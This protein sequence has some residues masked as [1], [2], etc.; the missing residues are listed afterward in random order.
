MPL[1]KYFVT[2]GKHWDLT[3][4]DQNE[5]ALDAHY[6][7]TAFYDMM[8]ERYGWSGIDGLGGELVSRVHV[9]GKYYVNA[10]WDG[11]RANFGNGDCDRYAPLTTLAIVGHEF[12]HGVT[13]YTSD[14]VYRNES[15]ALNESMSDIFGKALEY[16]EDPQNFNWILGDIIRKG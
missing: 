8:N 16:Y 6:S 12:M 11:N 1:E 3:N 7:T 14:L 4:E 15:G 10:Y 13:D 9:N 2:I 5:I